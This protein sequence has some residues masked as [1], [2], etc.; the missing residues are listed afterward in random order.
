M[1]KSLGRNPGEMYKNLKERSEIKKL[2]QEKK[3][4]ALQQEE[5]ERNEAAVARDM[6]RGKELGQEIIGDGLGRLKEDENVMESR[7]RLAE[8][9][10][11]MTSA[12]SLAQ[13]EQ[14]LENLQ[15]QE[16]GQ[17]RSLL[18]NLSN[19]G[20]TGGAA[21]AQLADLASTNLANRRRMET[22][23][24]AQQDTFGQQAARDTAKMDM[25]IAQFD[26]GQL[27]KE[28]NIDIQARLGYADM[29]SAE[30]S[31][32]RSAQAIESAAQ[33]QKGGGKK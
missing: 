30:R 8:M 16:Q 5:I 2:E 6:Q 33:A 29:G 9:A 19:A 24:A 10:K 1:L 7:G 13:R 27:A 22:Q 14:A 31:G 23:L 18:S 17:A 21:G 26:L 15:G 25:G 28:K 20:L 11:G 32:I 3:L 4:A 12:Q